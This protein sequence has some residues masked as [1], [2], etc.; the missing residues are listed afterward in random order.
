MRTRLLLLLLLVFTYSNA[1]VTAGLLQEFRFDNSYTNQNADVTFTNN[2]N[3]SFVADRFGN[4]NSA[5]TIQNQG[6]EAYFNS[7]PQGNNARTVSV[8]VVSQS[9][10]DN[11][12]FNYGTNA[13]NQA[14]G[15]SVQNSSVTN[16][17][18]GNDLVLNGYSIGANTW[19]HIVTTYDGTTAKIYYNGTMLAS[20]SKAWNT[21]GSAFRLGRNIN[22]SNG[23]YGHVD[24]LKIY[25]RAL[26][27]AEVTQLHNQPNGAALTPIISGVIVTP[28]TNSATIHYSL[29][30]NSANTTSVINWGFSQAVLT[31]QLTG[32]ST[33]GNTAN[34]GYV[35]INGLSPGTTYCYEIRATNINGTTTTSPTCFTTSVAPAL[36]SEYKFNNSLFNESNDSDFSAPSVSSHLYTT[37]RLGNPN[38]ALVVNS[39]RLYRDDITNIPKEDK[40]RSISLWIRPAA[41]NSDNILFTY[42][43]ASG[44]NVYGGSFNATNTYNFTYN[45]N[46]AFV[47]PTTVNN[48]KHIVITFDASKVAKIYVDGAYG[49]QNT[50]YTWY[51]S[52]T[53]LFYLGNSFGSVTGAFD[54][55]IDDL[56]IYNYALSA[57]EVSSLYT[58]NTLSSSD[59]SQ[60][61]LEVKL[62]PNPVND[63]LNIETALELQS[64]EI[65]NLQGQK[66]LSS[67]QKQINVSDLAAGMYMVRIQDAENNIATKKIVIK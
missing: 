11:Q 42:G 7:L 46:L 24:D 47:N 2:T 50:Q 20:G 36:I 3:T 63:I 12:V 56:K 8:W 37:D 61:N 19:V 51:T 54:G 40:P 1:Q 38:S 26:T 6:I 45:T 16:Y 62:Y 49:N 35:T 65:Y 4:A 33:T 39:S 25:N 67:N 64:V 5:L 31:N 15:F 48:W 59:F 55:A 9:T 28:T 23:F 22:G 13:T 14:Y 32:F 29:N 52:G 17:G 18:W 41:V 60:N 30:A 53:N 27:D 34:Q 10:V 57:A 66:V 21:P 44:N 58:S 43:S